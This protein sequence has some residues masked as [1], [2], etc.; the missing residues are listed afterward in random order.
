MS[1]A[2]K[3]VSEHI[4]ALIALA[5]RGLSLDDAKSRGDALDALTELE[6]RLF[7]GD[8]GESESDE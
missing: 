8:Q 5:R 4:R 3:I 6:A 7:P 1:E 2:K